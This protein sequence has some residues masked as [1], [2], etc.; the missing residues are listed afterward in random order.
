MLYEGA[1]RFLECSLQGFQADDPAEANQ[2]IN[3]NIQRAQAILDEL[4]AS[5]NLSDGGDLAGHLRGIYNYLD[6]RLQ[7]SNVRKE[8]DGIREVAARLAS[9]RDAWREML[10]RPVASSDP[11]PVGL[12][13]LG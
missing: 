5:L 7:E 1:I 3:N 2:T 10:T 12:T 9:L 6:R 13:A 11:L 8:A 4:N